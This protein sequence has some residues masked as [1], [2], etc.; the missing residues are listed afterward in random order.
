MGSMFLGG[1]VGYGQ[2]FCLQ[3]LRYCF[4]LPKPTLKATPLVKAHAQVQQQHRNNHAVDDGPGN[5]IL[6]RGLALQLPATLSDRA[7]GHSVGLDWIS[8][9]RRNH[10][11]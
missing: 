2:V 11:Q 3:A 10:Y 1:M 4:T 5:Q 9:H 6:P 8:G 7:R